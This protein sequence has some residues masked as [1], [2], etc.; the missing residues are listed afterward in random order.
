MN[1]AIHDMPLPAYIEPAEFAQVTL[2]GPA[3]CVSMPDQSDA[4]L[5][6]RRLSR[7]VVSEKVQIE[8]AAMLACARRGITIVIHDGD[9]GILARMIGRGDDLTG[10]RQRLMDLTVLPDWRERYQDWLNAQYRRIAMTVSRRTRAPRRLAYRPRLLVE[11]LQSQAV[12]R[13]GPNMAGQ[14]RR[15]YLRHGLVW[16]Q[17]SLARLGVDGTQAL[18]REGKPDLAGDLGRL[19]ALRMEPARLG[20]L[21]AM[22]R[23]GV[24]RPLRDKAVVRRLERLRPRLQRFDLDLVNRLY[25]WLSETEGLDRQ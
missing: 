9:D 7:L 16:M 24:N 20:W 18:W 15:L 21:E 8:T 12:E 1:D 2:D 23:A 5:P 6:L 11:W 19:L 22:A 14:T 13:V 25:I 4:W 3:L 17:H 10:L